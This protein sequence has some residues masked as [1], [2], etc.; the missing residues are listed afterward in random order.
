VSDFHAPFAALL[1]TLDLT[2]YDVEMASGTLT[3]TV[4]RDGGVDLEALTD[5]NRALSA[6][7]DEHDP[8]AGRY[9]L[10][11]CSPGL[12]RKLRTPEHFAHA[13]GE[14][15]TLRQRREGE[16]TRRLEGRLVSVEGSTLR[17]DDHEV[18]EVEVRLDS[19][20][21]A[22]TGLQLGATARS[23]RPRRDA[24]RPQR[25]RSESAMANFEFLDALGQIA[26]DQNI[27]EAEL[28]QALADALLAAYKRRDDSAEEAE[29]EINPE[30]GEIKVWGLE[31]DLEGNVVARV[32][33]RPDRL[34]SHRG[35]DG[36]AGPHAA[37]SRHSAPPDVRGVR[38][39]RG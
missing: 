32:G 38:Q 15:I 31:L 12:E 10:D 18:G 35:P 23:R 29:V 36:Q 26:R 37:D 4:T 1:A 30:T 28:L 22:R 7:L 11:V 3:V 24:R 19:L 21:R 2:L 6:W 5:A 25:K 8:I 34:R 9:T 39:P 14:T 33:H 16:P 13:I 27:D 20:E 17:I